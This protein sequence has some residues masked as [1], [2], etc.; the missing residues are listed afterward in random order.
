MR[1]I[2]TARH[3]V[4]VLAGILIGVVLSGGAHA[5]VE[6]A[7]RYETA[8]TAYLA[9]APAAFVAHDNTHDYFNDGISLGGAVDDTCFSA[10][11]ILPQGAKI[12]QLAVWNAK[13]SMIESTVVL[14][15]NAPLDHTLVILARLH[16]ENTNGVTELSKVGVPASKQVV[17]NTN[18]VYYVAQCLMSGEIFYGARIA[19]TYTSAG[20]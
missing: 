15:R 4:I 8:Q 2:V 18:F 1:I 16:P 20:D 10:P 5:I 7:F 9:L 6:K 11:V 3:V 13:N 14:G 19:Y 17:N 12:T